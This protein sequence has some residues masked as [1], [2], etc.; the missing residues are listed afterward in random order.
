MKTFTTIPFFR[1]LIPFVSGIIVGITFD[2]NFINLFYLVLLFIPIIF[3]NFYSAG[4]RSYKKFFLICA[5]VFLF[6]FGLNSVYL[7]DLNKQEY[8]Y[9]NQV[10]TDSV[11]NF[12]TIVNDLPV[13]K[14]KYIKCELKVLKV[15]SGKIYKDVRGTIVGYFKKSSPAY[16]L[17]QGQTILIKTQLTELL[18][19]KNPFE[20]DY[21]SYLYNKQIYHT[22]FIDS[23]SFAILNTKNNLTGIWSLGLSCKEFI[24]TRLANSVLSQNASAICA[25]LIAGYDDEI[26]RSVLE[27]FSHSGTLHVLSVSGLHTGLIY[28][29]LN[30]L[31]NLFDRKRKYYLTRFILITV[32]L[33][34]FALVTGF[35]AP[36]LRAVIM[37]NL[38]GY[39]RIYFRA[40]Y[41]NQLNILLVSAF[42]LLCYDPFYILDV[43]FLLSYFAL[44]GLIYYQPRFAAV[45]QPKNKLLNYSWQ[46]I[47]ASLA[48]TLSTLPLTLFYFKQFPLWFFI[49][50]LIV[51][52][53]TF[54][55]LVLAVFVIF[56]VGFVSL[57]V[58]SIVSALVFFINLFNSKSIGYVDSIYFYFN[59]VLFLSLFIVFL[60]VAFQ[61][62]SQKQ[63]KYSV[64]VL[65][66]WQFTSL[67][68]SYY[69][70]SDSLLCVYNAKNKTAV[71]IKNKTQVSLFCEDQKNYNFYIRPHLIS[72]NYPEVNNTLFNMVTTHER[73]ILILTKPGFWPNTDLAKI[74][75]LIL[76]NNFRLTEADFKLFS[77][78]QTI[79]LDASNNTRACVYAEE[80]SRKFGVNF[81][82]T[83]TMGAYQLT[84]L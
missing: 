42:V 4:K 5:D 30:A 48:A 18:A 44:F 51:V 11:L 3:L 24:L 10:S 66:F 56:K 16:H 39:G 19:P 32:F 27:A 65:I 78:L 82:A 49:C 57:L 35:S 67:I 80:L 21:K 36:V 63:L 29:A 55:L 84:L 54:L 17:K 53:A 60:S 73:S 47:T 72:F 69:C 77:N 61:Y 9:G 45:W 50:N 62:R 28:L 79:V 68:I 2:L 75:T 70:K 43:G 20:F 23:V 74:N 58:N 1:I 41:K 13:K 8:Y 37:F 34:A 6:L 22:A 64:L 33:W 7:K 81:H 38:L 25:A 15:K 12:I 14:E 26:D 46:S 31:F 40:Q 76:A 83:K 59:D 71:S 52:P